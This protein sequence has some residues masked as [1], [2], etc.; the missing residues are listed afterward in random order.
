MCKVHNPIE[1]HTSSTPFSEAVRANYSIYFVY[2]VSE[3][4]WEKKHLL[5]IFH[6]KTLLVIL[7]EESE[8]RP[9]ILET[10]VDE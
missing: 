4:Y 9:H 10:V 7:A 6:S 5:I 2:F 3:L 8:S 1:S